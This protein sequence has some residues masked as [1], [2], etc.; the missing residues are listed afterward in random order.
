MAPR[1][2][3]LAHL[4]FTERAHELAGLDHAQLFT[5][6]WRSNLWGADSSRSGLGS[7]DEATA[8][9]RGE[10][11]LLLS[12]LK[13]RSL[14]DIPCGDFGWMSRTDLGLDSYIGA[15]IVAGIV[16]RN[17][18]RYGSPDGRIGFR[19]LDLL[20]DTLPA[21]DAVLCRDCLVHLSFANIG[22]AL[23]NIR[24]S[25]AQWLIATTF[26]DHHDNRDITDGDWRLLNMETAPFGLPPAAFTLNEGCTEAGGAYAD[27]SLG[28]W[29][30]ADIP[31]GA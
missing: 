14:L 6:I 16:A 20:N 10:L 9:L 13:V 2:P 18:E 7:E 30:V 1:P 23:R 22:K 3:V 11:P 24:A 8:H 12:R 17:T 5:E 4:R 19:R 29:P 28:V 21:A 31:P 27:K 25:G 26:P 15:D